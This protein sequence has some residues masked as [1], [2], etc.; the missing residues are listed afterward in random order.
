LQI[1]LKRFSWHRV[2]I[3]SSGKWPC[4]PPPASSL[5]VLH[6]RRNQWRVKM[7]LSTRI[8][9]AALLLG[10]TFGM[11]TI[12]AHAAGCPSATQKAESEGGAGGGT[13]QQYAQKTESEG[14]AGGGTQQNF[15]QKTESEGGAGGGTQQAMAQPCKQ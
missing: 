2:I 5:N 11:T 1:T 8:A 9:F 7:R 14:G 4:C 13:Q 3:D 15:A 10:S 12:A 6:G